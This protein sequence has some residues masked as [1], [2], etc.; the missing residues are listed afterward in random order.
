MKRSIY[1]PPDAF[2]IS[3]MISLLP[4]LGRIG[5]LETLTSSLYARF[6]RVA[7]LQKDDA[8]SANSKRYAAESA[9]LKAVLDWLSVQPEGGSGTGEI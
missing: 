8:T 3:P 4:V 1:S 9:M 5:K 6:E 2:S 7:A